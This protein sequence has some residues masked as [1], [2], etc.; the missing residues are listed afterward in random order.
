MIFDFSIV[1]NIIS[2][3]GSQ[4]TVVVLGKKIIITIRRTEWYIS[5]V[6][7]DITTT[8]IFF[9]SSPVLLM[10]FGSIRRE[11][12]LKK[13]KFKKQQSKYQ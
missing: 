4:I 7:C 8:F 12:E 10:K 13:K 6:T 1:I 5:H 11:I 2:F 9:V 3:G